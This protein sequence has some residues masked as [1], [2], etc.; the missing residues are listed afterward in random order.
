MTDL[1][2]KALLLDLDDTI[3]DDSGSVTSA[4]WEVCEEAAARRSGLSA[5]NLVE[6]IFRVRDWYWADPERHRVGRQNLRAA[7]A[8][9]VNQALRSLGVENPALAHTIANAYRDRRDAAQGLFPGARETLAALVERGFPLALITNGAAAS[10]R[11]KIERFDLAKYFQHV[12]IEG[13]F[14][15]G[16]PDARVY[17]HALEMLGATA[18]RTWMVGDNLEWEILAPSRL[19]LGTVWIDRHGNGVPSESPA[20]PD[21]I[22]RSLEELLGLTDR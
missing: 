14:G 4:W 9:I 2:P 3:L 7:S 20:R 16:K 18:E 5:A 19:G 12:L 17:H 10:Q 21:F 15:A 6:E 1:F 11:A 13:E 22:I 8:D